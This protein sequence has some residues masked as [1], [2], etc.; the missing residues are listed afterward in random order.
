MN[1]LPL[2][3]YAAA[4]IAYAVHFAT[5]Q[6]QAGRAATALLILAALA[7][8]FVMERG[9]SKLPRPPISGKAHGE[10]PKIPHL[11]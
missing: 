4:G 8:T 7:H 10:R 1:V 11:A 6:P 5:R 3:L 9:A 2:V